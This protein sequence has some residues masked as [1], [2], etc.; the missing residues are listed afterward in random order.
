MPNSI[1]PPWLK[2]PQTCVFGNLALDI[3]GIIGMSALCEREQNPDES[4][5][6]RRR[7]SRCLP[8][9]TDAVCPAGG[10]AGSRDRRTSSRPSAIRTTKPQKMGRRI[11]RPRGNSLNRAGAPAVPKE[12]TDSSVFFSIPFPVSAPLRRTQGL[13]VTANSPAHARRLELVEMAR[14]RACRGEPVETVQ[15]P[16]SKDPVD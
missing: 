6:E 16:T 2:A 7:E 14:P 4:L 10:L 9:S 5:E 3:F 8:A 11:R 15:S 12:A 1:R 13:A